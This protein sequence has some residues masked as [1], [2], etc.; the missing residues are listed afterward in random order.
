MK[1]SHGSHRA[2]W[3]CHLME[4]VVMV[5]WW[6]RLWIFLSSK[7]WE[8]PQMWN[9]FFSNYRISLGFQ[10]SLLAAGPPHFQDKAEALLTCFLSSYDYCLKFLGVSKESL[11]QD[12]C[13]RMSCVGKWNGCKVSPSLRHIS[14]PILSLLENKQF[15]RFTLEWPSDFLWSVTSLGLAAKDNW[16]FRPAGAKSR[17]AKLVKKPWGF[18]GSWGLGVRANAWEACSSVIV[19]TQGYLHGVSYY[20]Y[21]L[22]F[23]LKFLIL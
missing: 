8:A 2:M 11:G 21:K 9:F 16:C 17:A 18:G 5:L 22:K 7:L 3:Q 14:T 10:S 13:F 15:K 1:P 12:T 20:L 23:I 4:L 6:A 19:E